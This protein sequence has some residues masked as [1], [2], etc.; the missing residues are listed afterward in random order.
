[1]PI[2]L[3]ACSGIIISLAAFS[4]FDDL[5]RTQ[6][7]TEFDRHA[8]S[9]T[10]AINSKIS[11]SFALLRSIRGLFGSSSKVTRSDFAVFVELLN[12]GNTVQALEWIPR[13]RKSDRENYEKLAQEEGL[14]GF[15]ITEREIQGKMVPAGA[16][17]E[18]FPVYYVEPLNENK[19]AVG[20]D[21]ASNSARLKALQKARDS[22]KIIA[23]SRITLVQE[24][25][26]QYGFLA[27]V[28][29]YEKG[30]VPANLEE[31]QQKITGF[32]LGVY[33]VGDLIKSALQASLDRTSDLNIYI[34]DESAQ[35]DGHLL[36]PRG[37]EAQAKSILDAPVQ[38]KRRIKVAGRVWSIVVTPFNSSTFLGTQWQSWVI[39]AAGLLITGVLLLYNYSSSMRSVYS[40]KLV[41]KRT[42]DLR[43]SNTSLIEAKNKAEAALAELASRKLAMDEH[44]IVAV[45]DTK[46]TITYANDKFCQ[47][48][49]Y[50]R[51]ELIGKNHR[52]LNSGHHPESFFTEMYRTIANGKTW[53]DEIKNRA[54]DGSHYWVDTTITPIK[55]ANGNVVQYVANR[56]DITG[57]YKRDKAIRDQNERFSIALENMSQGLCVF[58]RQKRII[59]SNELYASMYGLPKELVVP[60]T[61]LS[62]VI[63]LRVAHGLYAGEGPDEYIEERL[64]WGEN[65]TKQGVK[66]QELSDGRSIR[67]L[68]Q[69]LTGGGWVATHE[70]ITESMRMER[71]KNEFVSVVSHELR[72]P[73]TS[74][75]GSLRLMTSGSLGEIPDKVNS[76][77]GIACR[78][79][80]RLTRLV[81]DILDVEKINSN[82]MDFV[83]APTDIV[84]L[85][86]RAI[87]ENKAYGVENGVRLRLEEN[88]GAAY[89]NVDEDRMMQ[90]LANILSN[91]AKF[92]PLESEVVLRLSRQCGALRL[93][94]DD[95]GSGIPKGKQSQLFNRF[96]QVDASDRRSKQ[97]TGLGLTI[98]KAIVEKHGSQI[99]V[100]SEVGKGSTFYFDLE[101][102]D[103]PSATQNTEV[104]MKT[105]AVT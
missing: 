102:V 24:T 33:R 95:T 103:A 32:G 7:I 86:Q 78:N 39:L 82:H 6:R 49:G 57:L 76:L 60:G 81:N 15:R 67:I 51:E 53:H 104:D 31:R 90:V 79:T 52:I 8:Y 29:I 97:G 48:S 83:F 62:E 5:A 72:T 26:N 37:A 84:A 58:D 4:Y 93:A 56:T 87:D 3:V 27:F 46:G 68:R 1:M 43:H 23:S 55:D 63:K 65:R 14:T 105:A 101:E 12:I 66:V 16:R 71:L 74:L 64:E 54:K 77:L 35:Q 70:D 19:S 44:A 75:S 59:V 73:L 36:Y 50:S 20:F 69:P 42:A 92:S 89:A 22:G 100:E 41:V 88:L 40:E 25:E 80:E 38:Y 13:V 11:E 91:A 99:I 94:V 10:E 28:P 17:D 2:L 34:F 45:T 96:F 21:L 98:V 47:I 9:Q 18:Y 30:V 61:P 85:A